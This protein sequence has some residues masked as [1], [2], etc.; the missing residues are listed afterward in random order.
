MDTSTWISLF[1]LVIGL[2]WAWWKMNERQIA[3]GR[4]KYW[5]TVS[6]PLFY[7]SGDI[8]DDT[9]TARAANARKK[10]VEHGNVF[11]NP[12]SDVWEEV[13]SASNLTTSR[14][15]SQWQD[16][17]LL[18]LTKRREL[19]RREKMGYNETAA[20]Q[21]FAGQSFEWQASQVTEN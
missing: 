5:S 19:W 3:D 17:V 18:S 20:K 6:E 16:L 4:A 2:A 15:F 14:D 9:V 7:I 11:L 12:Q 8:E 13:Y 10:L 21:Q 1:G